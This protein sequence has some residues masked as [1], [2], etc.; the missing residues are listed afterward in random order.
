M[1]ASKASPLVAL[2]ALA[3]V[4]ST[5]S[6]YGNTSTQGHGNG[7]TEQITLASK[8]AGGSFPDLTANLFDQRGKRVGFA[9]SDCTVIIRNPSTTACH[10]SFVLTGRGEITWQH[11]TRS[12]QPP[13]FL[14]ITGGTGRYCEASGQ[15]R[16][17]RTESSPQGG[18]YKLTV[19]TGRACPV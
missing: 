14:A 10:G 18:L 12:A 15:V 16:V 13:Y 17:V 2:T 19:F 11:S 1:K 5:P 9:T 3:L 7:G 4:F 6:A 8:R